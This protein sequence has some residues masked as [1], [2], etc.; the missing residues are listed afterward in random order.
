ML[1]LTGTVDSHNI[2]DILVVCDSPSTYCTTTYGVPPRLHEQQK[3]DPE[4]A[5]QAMTISTK[6]FADSLYQHWESHLKKFKGRQSWWYAKRNRDML[7]KLQAKA[8][9]RWGNGWRANGFC[10]EKDKE[11]LEPV[12]AR[13]EQTLEATQDRPWNDWSTR[14]TFPAAIHWSG[15]CNDRNLKLLPA[16]KDQTGSKYWWGRIGT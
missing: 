10:Q 1:S 11:F 12:K 15:Y 4:K 16:G 3:K 13:E 5:S 7:E 2:Y 8:G 6:I 9:T 14:V